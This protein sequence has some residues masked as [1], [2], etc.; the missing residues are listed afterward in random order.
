M[1]EK[2]SNSSA[3][4]ELSHQIQDHYIF[5]WTLELMTDSVWTMTQ[6]SKKAE[7]EF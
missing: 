7:Y 2:K 6:M 5:N 1:E 4:T 3:P